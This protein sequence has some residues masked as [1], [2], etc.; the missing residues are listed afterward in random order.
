[1]G[2]LLEPV[3]AGLFEEET[4]LRVVSPQERLVHSE[5]PW[6]RATLDGIVVVEGKAAGPLESKTT[7]RWNG[8]WREGVPDYYQVQLLHQMDVGGFERG[9]IATLIDGRRFLWWEFERNQAD[10]AALVALEAAFWRR[11]VERRP[12]PVDGSSA[13]HEA[14]RAAHAVPTGEIKELTDEHAALVEALRQARA[15]EAVAKQAATLAENKVLAVLEGAVE[16]TY[17]GGTILRWPQYERSVADLKALRAAGIE[18][19]TK[20]TPYRQLRLV[21]TKEG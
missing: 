1:M 10:I 19:P 12:P 14:L 6:Q 9:W 5:R 17:G 13:T 4:G 21:G 3:I 16:A 11:V 15:A 18:I 20:T 7:L 8:D 2:R